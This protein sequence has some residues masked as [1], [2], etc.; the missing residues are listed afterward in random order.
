MSIQRDPDGRRSVRVEVELPGSPEQV[1]QAIATGPGISAW[2]VPTQVDGR[3][4]GEIVSDF[5]PGMMSTAKITAWNPP[6]RFAA[7]SEGWAPGMPPLAT[8]WTVETK[9]GG[10]CI[11]RVVHS[12]FASSDEWDQQIEG[13]ETGWASFFRVLRRYLEHFAGEAS[14]LVQA[15]AMTGEPVEKAWASLTA[16]MLGGEPKPGQPLSISLS[17]GVALAGKVERIDDLGH[18]HN[19]QVLLETPAPGTLLVGA[20]GCG[21]TMVSASAYFYGP[22]AEQAATATR[23]HLSSWI[24]TQFPA[25][26][27]P[28]N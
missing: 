23:P 26:S 2:F 16:A 8:E 20:Y 15:S 9:D 5:G 24:A 22:H 28:T 11:V 25:P 3:S 17:P 7:T 18:G 12:L 21:G 10:A 1:W 19:L 6:F 4:G 14:A 27:V 13:T